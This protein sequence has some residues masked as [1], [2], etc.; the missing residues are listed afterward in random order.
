[1]W[2]LRLSFQ[3]FSIPNTDQISHSGNW[4]KNR[5]SEVLQ[6]HSTLFLR[7]EKLENL[8]LSHFLLSCNF[9]SSSILSLACHHSQ[10]V[11]HKRSYVASTCNSNNF[12]NPSITNFNSFHITQTCCSSK[13]VQNP[14][15]REMLVSFCPLVPLHQVYRQYEDN[16]QIWDIDCLFSTKL[17][18]I[19]YS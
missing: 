14:Y 12:L 4:I 18:F 3:E 2:R 11:F 7:K 9:N 15:C 16:V 1:M 6:S 10:N 19:R 8:N 17:I 13:S 5:F